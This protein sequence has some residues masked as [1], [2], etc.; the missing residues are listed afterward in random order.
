MS[1][2]AFM[3]AMRIRPFRP[4]TAHMSSGRA[5]RISHPEIVACEENSTIALVLDPQ[6]GF[7]VLDLPLLADL[8]FDPVP[9]TAVD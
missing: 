5:I 7:A 4:F 9:Q 3:V 6:S 8:Q 2:S 1:A